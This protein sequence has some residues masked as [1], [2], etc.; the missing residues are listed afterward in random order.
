MERRSF[1]VLTQVAA[2]FEIVPSEVWSLG[3][4]LINCFKVTRV[5]VTKEED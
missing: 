3:P 1:H 2:L 4:V 5:R